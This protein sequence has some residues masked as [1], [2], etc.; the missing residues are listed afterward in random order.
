MDLLDGGEGNDNFAFNLVTDLFASTS[1]VAL[2]DSIL[3]GD[4]TDTLNILADGF[5]ISATNTFARASGVEAIASGASDNPFSITLDAS[6]FAAGIRTVSLASDFTGTIGNNTID[7][8]RQ[9]DAS[10]GLSLVG[11]FGVDSITG[12][13]GNDTV[14]GSPGADVLDGGAGDDTF[15]FNASAHLFATTTAVDLA[16]TTLTGGSGT[17]T[18]QVNGNGFTITTSNTFARASGVEAIASGAS[19]HLP[20]QQLV[21]V[22]AGIRSV[23][24][25]ADTNATGSNTINAS[26]Q[27]SAAIALSLTGSAGVDSITGGSGND[28]LSGGGGG[29]ALNGGAG[30]DQ[31]SVGAGDSPQTGNDTITGFTT[32]DRIDFGGPQAAPP[33]TTKAAASPTKASPAARPTPPFALASSTTSP[34]ATT[35][36][37]TCITTPTAAQPSTSS[38]RKWCSPA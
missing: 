19:D 29:D 18:L 4:G 13:A 20:R 31:F 11:S 35:A 17:D 32:Q 21:I 26:S 27:T 22:T 14:T 30:A 33:T 12:G 2:T 34:S 5:T 36:T 28:T 38:T 7:A 25:A 15:V 24:L 6:A 3:G 10:I 8:S 9:L 16:D 23:T 37:A 1:T